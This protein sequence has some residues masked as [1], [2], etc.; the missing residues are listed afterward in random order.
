LFVGFV[1][2]GL[3]VLHINKGK[4]NRARRI[5]IYGENGV[6]KSS[7]AAKFPK[8]LFF[9]I[10]DGIGDLD[11]DSTEVIRS[12]TDFMGCMIGASETDYETIVIDTVDW[13][14]KLIFADV[15]QKAGKKTIDDIGFGKGYQAVEQQWKSLFDG[16]SYLWQ[17]GRHIV[18][19][20]HEQIEKFTN[21]DGDS[22][23]YWKP[24][25]HIKGSGCVTEWCDEV[26]FVRYRTLTRQMDEGFGNK[27]SIAIG[28]KER[29]IVCNKSATVE[30][31]NRLGMV[32]EISSFADLQKYLPIVSKQTVAAPAPSQEKPA[33]NIAG[34]VKNGTS[35]GEALAVAEPVDL[36]D[37]PF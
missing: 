37:S 36:S 13:L 21:P 35:K 3:I 20:C 6:G 1:F 32:D 5:L 28:G 2:R 11:V 4:R 9:N 14:E 16:L 17:Q 12:I 10:E 27:R 33:G 29:V 26:L 23:N 31:K 22:Y 18:F 19:T 8:P 25:L 15:A 30:A 7:L 34:V 24:A